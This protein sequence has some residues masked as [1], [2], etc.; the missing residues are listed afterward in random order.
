[1]HFYP[2]I[3]WKGDSF[4]LFAEDL[5]KITQIDHFNKNIKCE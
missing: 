5:T 4:K 3:Y 2:Y 1:M